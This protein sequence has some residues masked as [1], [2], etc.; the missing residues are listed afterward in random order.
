M[1]KLQY[2]SM[3]SQRGSLMIEVLIAIA[4]AVIGVW[5]L[6]EMQAKLHK[7]EM[8]AYQRTQ[9]V[10]LLNDMASRIA[11]NRIN[12]GSYVTADA[13]ADYLGAGMVCPA[14]SSPASVKEIDYR[15]WCLA[16]LGAGETQS[17]A[18][19]GAMVGARGCVEDIGSG[20]FMVT[21]VWQGMT[22]ISVPPASVA[23]GKASPN[24]YDGGAM[25]PLTQ[26][27]GDLCRR[28]ATTIVGVAAL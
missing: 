12:A 14:L 16:L 28:F 7:S 6:M 9:A 26:C 13:T 5:A 18:S 15:E 27:T 21:I 19:V 24:P 8:E 1:M 10:M 2:S 3:R 11:T 17:G 20:Q 25:N 23:C 4:I 22:P